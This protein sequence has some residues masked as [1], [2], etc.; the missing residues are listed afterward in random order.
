MR[1]LYSK[2]KQDSIRVF[3]FGSCFGGGRA[4]GQHRAS[5]FSLTPY[6][7]VRN[8]PHAA[9]TG[10]GIYHKQATT[11]LW[12]CE[13]MKRDPKGFGRLVPVENLGSFQ[14]A[15]GSP[16][17]AKAALNMTTTAC[18]ADTS[19][20]HCYLRAGVR[21]LCSSHSLASSDFGRRSGA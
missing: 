13:G 5:L 17:K 7:A 18:S 10:K 4:H 19:N 21:G 12:T 11:L 1:T 20:N 6:P 15:P 14:D 16:A 9:L 8:G 3:L 2:P